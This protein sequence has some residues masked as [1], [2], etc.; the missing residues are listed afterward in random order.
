MSFWLLYTPQTF[1]YHRIK[2]SHL[3]ERRSPFGFSLVHSVFSILG[4]SFS[5]FKAWE[6]AHCCTR[7]FRGHLETTMLESEAWCGKALPCSPSQLPGEFRQLMMIGSICIL[8]WG[9]AGRGAYGEIDGL[10]L[11]LIWGNRWT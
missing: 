7:D 2:K 4:Y 9:C 11:F 1:L 6:P 3:V 5:H 8:Q 10:R